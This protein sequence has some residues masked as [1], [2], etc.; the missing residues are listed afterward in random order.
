[1]AIGLLQTFEH[2]LRPS[3]LV[4]AWVGKMTNKV[5][6]ADYNLFQGDRV[7]PQDVSVYISIIIQL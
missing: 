1:M 5:M 3:A 6:V 2:L 7:G 4:W